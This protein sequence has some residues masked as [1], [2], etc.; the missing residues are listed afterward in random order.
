MRNIFRLR[1]FYFPRSDEQI[2]R[3]IMNPTRENRPF[4]GEKFHHFGQWTETAV[5]FAEKQHDQNL[6]SN[7]Q[8]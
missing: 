2:E 7:R 4:V 1:V 6:I 8:K 3:E 5:G